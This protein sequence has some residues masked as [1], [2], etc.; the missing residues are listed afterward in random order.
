[1]Y[2]HVCVCVCLCVC[3]CVCVCVRA[4]VRACMHACVLIW[5][6]VYVCVL[7]GVCVCMHVVCVC[8]H[9]WLY[10]CVYACI[11]YSL[12][13]ECNFWNVQHFDL[14]SV[15]LGH[16]LVSAFEHVFLF[17]YMCFINVSSSL[18]PFPTRWSQR[19]K[20]L[21]SRMFCPGHPPGWS[22]VPAYPFG[23]NPSISLLVS[24]LAFSLALSCQQL[25]AFHCFLPISI[26]YI[27]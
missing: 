23:R 16:V 21:I 12:T 26:Q 5:M 3:V 11:S 17:R 20:F 13:L 10:V 8:V 2:M 19:H 6:G 24:P 22:A 18:S 15:G 27:D 25:V 14:S 9:A 7:V 4:C 1:M